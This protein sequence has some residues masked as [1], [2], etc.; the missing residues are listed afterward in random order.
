MPL[1]G[2]FGRIAGAPGGVAL[3]DKASGMREK[4][5]SGFL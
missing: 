4:F 5:A 3:K 1:R 2:T